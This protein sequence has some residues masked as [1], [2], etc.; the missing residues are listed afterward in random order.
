MIEPGQEDNR[1][2]RP[3]TASM[4]DITHDLDA[5]YSTRVW[6]W[7]KLPRWLPARGVVYCLLV[8]RER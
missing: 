4:R 3:A 2:L 8:W 6:L 7:R 1:H 5:P